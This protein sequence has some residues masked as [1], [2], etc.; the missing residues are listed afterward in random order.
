MPLECNLTENDHA[1]WE[2]RR[3]KFDVDNHPLRDTSKESF[4]D[5]MMSDEADLTKHGFV[6]QEALM[7]LG[8]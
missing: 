5:A 7:A 8:S 2:V 4:F 1:D 3:K 6:S